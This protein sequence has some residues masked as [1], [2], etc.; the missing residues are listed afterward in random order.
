MD[1]VPSEL[2]LLLS[3]SVYSQKHEIFTQGLS[4][5]E[6]A[7]T[8]DP[9]V[10]H[11]NRSSV[12]F[13]SYGNPMIQTRERELSVTSVNTSA[14]VP[15]E[16]GG[17]GG[18]LYSNEMK[19]RMQLFSKDPTSTTLPPPPSMKAPQQKKT[20]RTDTV[21]T[22]FIKQMSSLCHHLETTT[23]TFIRCVKPNSSMTAG[24]FEHKFV[25]EQVRVLGIVQ[26]CEVLKQGLP[27]RVHF[28]EIETM[29]RSKFTDRARQLIRHLDEVQFTKAVLWALEIPR[30][31]Y[32]L[33]KTRIFFNSSNI[34]AMDQLLRVKMEE[35][36][37]GGG[38]AREGEGMVLMR[39]VVQ[40]VMR[41]YW[42]RALLYARCRC[43]MIKCWKRAQRRCQCAV[44][45][46]RGWKRYIGS[47]RRI[48]KYYLRSLWRRAI[49]FTIS[50]NILLENYQ[51]IREATEM[52][53]K[54]EAAAEER[55]KSLQEEERKRSETIEI[56]H[57]RRRMS[58]A[59]L[60]HALGNLVSRL[61]MTD[62]GS[63]TL[64]APTLSSVDERNEDD[65]EEDEEMKVMIEATENAR[66]KSEMRALV[67][68]SAL[69]TVSVCLFR[70]TKIKLFQ[71]FEKWHD[72]SFYSEENSPIGVGGGTGVGGAVG[73]GRTRV[74]S[75][76][77]KT[78]QG[79]Q[80]QSRLEMEES[81]KEQQQ[82]RQGGEENAVS[83]VCFECQDRTAQLWCSSC[84][85]V[86]RTPA[87]PSSLLLSDKPP[88]L[89]S[90]IAPCAVNSFITAL[91]S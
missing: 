89:H 55:M 39:R 1:T 43:E 68:A 49:Y 84:L 70:W 74:L 27:S 80:R 12:T 33:G 52:R 22:T 69:A 53:L 83:Y 41:R 34:T 8:L 62:D 63:G 29:Y 45:V 9:S 60:G 18:P 58:S 72:A 85:Q 81:Y 65:E 42:R 51:L 35:I 61:S 90:L 48:R 28:L 40:Y 87:P 11:T 76:L 38:G 5:K 14:A 47:V 17:S 30:S 25:M 2:Y 24:L 37:E 57:T 21:G 59:S 50:A 36:H 67:A 31:K 56:I 88:P 23:C 66:A 20:A 71:A 91:A 16:D 78:R 10:Y 44:V 86:C 15:E 32:E 73:G 6:E 7:G 26:T 3:S 79:S 75:M 13:E 77:Q 19:T 4:V 64:R 82:Q 46:Q 54:A